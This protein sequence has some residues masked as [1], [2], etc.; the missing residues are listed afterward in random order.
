MKSGMFAV[1]LGCALLAGC[2]GGATAPDNVQPA[3]PEAESTVVPPDWPPADDP[4]IARED[5]AGQTPDQVVLALIEARNAADW[6]T[7]YSLYA[8]A[9]VDYET[10]LDEWQ[11]I[12]EV[13][14]DFQVQ[15]TLVCSEELAAVR[16]TYTMD[17]EPL[18]ED[19]VIVEEPGQ[20]WPVNKIDGLWKVH[21]MPVQ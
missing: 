6:Q 2:A 7:A 17:I 20:W 5:E 14:S 19:L 11:S 3:V 13:Y 1:F 16:V 18:G 4:T 10:A 9:T 21:W 12:D 8:Y 15:E